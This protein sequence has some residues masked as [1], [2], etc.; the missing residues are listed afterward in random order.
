VGF[1]D[2]PPLATRPVAP[3]TA[4]YELVTLDATAYADG[5]SHNLRFA[6]SNPTADLGALTNVSLDDISLLHART[7]PDRLGPETVIDKTPPKTVRLKKRNKKATVLFGF[8]SEAG[9]TFRCSLDGK[10]PVDCASPFTAK[11]GKGRHSFAVA[12]TDAAGNA[13]ATPPSFSFQVKKA[14]RTRGGRGRS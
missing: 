4:G 9:A 14:K 10:Q 3:V 13:D 12:A 11:V 1:D 8:T 7:S 6:L 2:D 5:Q